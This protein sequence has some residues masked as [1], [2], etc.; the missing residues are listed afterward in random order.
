MRSFLRLE[1]SFSGLKFAVPSGR[2]EKYSRKK[3]EQAGLGFVY[4]DTMPQAVKNCLRTSHVMRY[5]SLFARMCVFRT[6]S[7]DYLDRAEQ[8]REKL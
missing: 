4:A 5:S 2:L 1:D 3:C 6:I 7:G 8:F